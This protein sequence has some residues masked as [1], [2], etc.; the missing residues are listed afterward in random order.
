MEIVRWSVVDGPKDM[1]MGHWSISA[2]H[3]DVLVY[4]NLGKRHGDGPLVYIS[5]TR[6]RATGL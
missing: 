4:S 1:E 2:R 6:R 5:K 3:G